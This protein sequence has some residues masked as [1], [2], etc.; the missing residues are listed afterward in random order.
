MQKIQNLQKK[1]IDETKA[2]NDNAKKIIELYEKLEK[3]DK[4]INEL[5]NNQSNS[6]NINNLMTVIFVSSEL[7]IHYSIICKETDIFTTLENKLYEVYPEC[8]EC[9]C[10]C[11]ANDQKI[12]R[13]K[14]LQENKI[15]NCQIIY[16]NKLTPSE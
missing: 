15:K 14:T 7:N 12:K 5:K 6:N 1:L 3:K 4:E 8:K 2:K 16:I 11:I 13:F 10:C 9:E